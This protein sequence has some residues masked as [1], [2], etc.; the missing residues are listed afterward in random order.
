MPAPTSNPLATQIR[1]S[2]AALTALEKHEGVLRAITD[3]LAA[4]LEAGGTIYLCGNGGSAADAQHVAAEF[5]GRFLRERRPLPALALTCNTSILTAVGND[6][7]FA[8]VFARQVRAHVTSRDCVVGIS[9]SGRSPNVLR[10][11][12]AA[13]DLGA[14]TI[15]FTGS[16]GHDLAVLCDVC[17]LAPSASTPRIQEAHLLAWHLVC[18]EVERRVVAGAGR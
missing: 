13:R 14:T 5:V 3:R 11:V 18:D 8:E 10:A 6:Y 1:E 2:V 12:S 16:E 15:G 9:T 4:C 7:E 17:L